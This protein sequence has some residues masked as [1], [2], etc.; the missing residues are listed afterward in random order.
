MSRKVKAP[1]QNLKS[2]MTALANS[3]GS[4]RHDSE[5][6]KGLT[7]QGLI[8]ELNGQLD[9]VFAHLSSLRSKLHPVIQVSAEEAGGQIGYASPTNAPLS[10]ELNDLRNRMT[11]LINSITSLTDEV[12]L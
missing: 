1:S 4:L 10:I 2:A 8:A 9:S 5:Q 6:P 3:A 12:D 11:S 7:P